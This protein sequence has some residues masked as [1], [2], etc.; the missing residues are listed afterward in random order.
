VSYDKSGDASLHESHC[1][2]VTIMLIVGERKRRV[3]NL[4]YVTWHSVH[5]L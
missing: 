4:K 3:I 5:L 1:N 2:L